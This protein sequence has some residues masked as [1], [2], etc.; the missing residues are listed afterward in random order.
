[1]VDQIITGNVTRSVPSSPVVKNIQIKPFL[2]KTPI[3]SIKTETTKWVKGAPTPIQE[4]QLTPNT[5]ALNLLVGF[6]SGEVVTE[7]DELKHLPS[8]S[9]SLETIWDTPRKRI[10]MA[11]LIEQKRP[12]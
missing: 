1:M 7:G 11:V 2:H 6:A 3:S 8:I 12:K 4:G 9:K 10:S 5:E